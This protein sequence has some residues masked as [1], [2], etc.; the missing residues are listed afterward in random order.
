MPFSIRVLIV[1]F[2]V[3]AAPAYAQDTG[4]GLTGNVSLV[5][6]SKVLDDADWAPV[7]EHEEGGVVVDLGDRSWPIGFELRFLHSKSDTVFEP[8]SGLSVNMDTTEL[9]LGIR[10]TWGAA[11][12][13]PYL[14]G[15]LA[16]ID[17]DINFPGLGTASDS[18]YGFWLAGG[19]YWVLAEHLV[20]GL[21]LMGS[22]AEADYG[23]GSN[24]DIGGGHFHFVL[25]YHF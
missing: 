23:S 25:G 5:A 10:K 1:A 19:I 22:S 8:I 20:L 13:H 15:G 4:S 7:E 9:D 16:R 17:A 24:F 21:D 12:M 11:S 14:T 18:A 6:G 3:A 2:V